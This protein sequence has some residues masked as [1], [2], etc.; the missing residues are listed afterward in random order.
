MLAGL[1]G[2]GHWFMIAHGV[3]QAADS[4]ARAAIAGL[5]DAERAALV[6]DAVANGTT[7]PDRTR[8]GVETARDGSYYSVTLRYDLRG[9]GLVAAERALG[10][11]SRAGKLVLTLALER[12]AAWYRVP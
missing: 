5:D 10:W 3:Q 9:E 1:L 6:A 4:A 2:Y 7:V 11:P 12:V 8:L